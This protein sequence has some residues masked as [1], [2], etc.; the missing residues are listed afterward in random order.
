MGKDLALGKKAVGLS[1]KRAY[2]RRGKVA[3]SLV[4]Q[5]VEN[6]NKAIR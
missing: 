5:D 6:K 4:W 2:D 1:H 3:L